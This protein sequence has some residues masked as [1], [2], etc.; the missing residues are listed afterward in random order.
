MGERGV[1][2]LCAALAAVLGTAACSHRT[3]DA[4]REASPVP[5]RAAVTGRV[6]DR[7]TGGGLSGRTVIAGEQRV[8]TAADG[9][10]TLADVPPLYD[11]AI[12]DAGG[13]RATIYPKLARPDP[14]LVH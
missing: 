2:G 9:S 4:G 1:L 7:R 8:A 11:L 12:V 3:V 6:V 14:L 10:F 13:T 5:A